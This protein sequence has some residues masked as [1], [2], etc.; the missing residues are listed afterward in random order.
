MKIFLNFK[1]NFVNTCMF[2]ISDFH[3]PSQCKKEMKGLYYNDFK[4]SK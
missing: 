4:G 3:K 2:L 1:L